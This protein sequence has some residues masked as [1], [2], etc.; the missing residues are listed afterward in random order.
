MT[1]RICY[2][3]YIWAYPE[4]AK[5]Y[6]DNQYIEEDPWSQNFFPQENTRPLIN[7]SGLKARCKGKYYKL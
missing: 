5:A 2:T 4:N 7:F 3:I 1:K 6:L